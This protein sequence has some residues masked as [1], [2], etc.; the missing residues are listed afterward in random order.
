MCIRDSFYAET[1]AMW[2]VDYSWE[3][4]QWIVPD[5]SKQ[6]VIAFLRRDAAGKMIMVVCNFNP[7]LREKYQMGVPNPGTYKEIMSSDDV[8]YGGSGLTNGSVK[9]VKGE[10]HGF[11][12]HI[13]IDLPPLSTLYFSVPAARKPRAKKEDA[14]AEPKAEAKTAAKPAAKK[15]AKARAESAKAEPAAK[16]PAAKKP[17]AAKKA[18]TPEKA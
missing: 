18:R 7:V 2:Q 1:P 11:D 13:A 14:N 3:G 5:D 16:K 17:A 10:L 9:S 15:T 4:F 6:S 8:K 12:Q